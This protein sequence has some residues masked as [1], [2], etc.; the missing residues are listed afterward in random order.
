VAQ[1]INLR[2]INA[3]ECLDQDFVTDLDIRPRRSYVPQQSRSRARTPAGHAGWRSGSGSCGCR[4]VTCALGRL[5]ENVRPAL[6]P[7]CGHV[8]GLGQAGAGNA[9]F[10]AASQEERS[11]AE[12]W[13]SFAAASAVVGRRQ[14][15]ALRSARDRIPK[16][17]DGRLRVY[18]RLAVLFYLAERDLEVAAIHRRRLMTGSGSASCA[19]YWQNSGAI[20]SRERVCMFAPLPACGERSRSRSDR[21]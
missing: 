5:R 14:A 3:L 17:A 21:G 8:A 7:V 4:F 9:R 12:R 11:G 2:L 13:R 6:R 10:L 16:D 15:S 18:R 19:S 20:A 1:P